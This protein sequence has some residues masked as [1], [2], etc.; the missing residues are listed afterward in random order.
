MQRM[1]PV[2]FGRHLLTRLPGR[3]AEFSGATPP[4]Y[5]KVYAA[6]VDAAL[7]TELINGRHY[8][9]EQDLPSIAADLR[10]A[11]CGLIPHSQRNCECG[12]RLPEIV[13]SPDKISL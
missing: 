9:R 4:N 10:A 5:R 1:K 6:A 2:P 8:W 3:L 12:D 7:P 13:S 11:R